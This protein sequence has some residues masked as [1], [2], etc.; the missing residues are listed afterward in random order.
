M[1]AKGSLMGAKRTAAIVV[2]QSEC[3][4]LEIPLV[5][6]SVGRAGSEVVHLSWWQGCQSVNREL[7]VGKVEVVDERHV[8]VLSVWWLHDQ[9]ERGIKAKERECATMHGGGCVSSCARR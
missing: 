5:R 2:T 7:Y 3:G 8:E 6:V 9:E 4:A 1:N